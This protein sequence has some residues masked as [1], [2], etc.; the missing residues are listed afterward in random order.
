KLDEAAARQIAIKQAVGIVVS[1]SIERKGSGYEVVVKAAQPVTGNVVAEAKRSASGKDQVLATVT[2]L[3]ATVR[4]V[5]GDKT[6]ESAQLFA[7]KSISTTS[8]EAL[9]RY[10]AGVELQSKGKF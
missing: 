8:L 6:S 10:A 1:G 9:E 7:M 3:A 4:K 2:T 5:L